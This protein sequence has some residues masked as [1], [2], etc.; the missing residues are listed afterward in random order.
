MSMNLKFYIPLNK[1]LPF[2]SIRLATSTSEEKKVVTSP[3]FGKPVI[4]LFLN[5]NSVNNFQDNLKGVLLG[6]HTHPLMLDLNENY[7]VMAFH[8]KPYALKQLL[9]T[10]AS[11]LT[12]K[13][14]SIKGIKLIESLYELVLKYIEDEKQLIH[15]INDFFE[16]AELHD[17]SH[18]VI[19]FLK[20]LES[21]KPG[22]IS[23]MVKEIGLTERNLERKFKCEVGLSP[24]KY[25]QIR[26]V[27]EVFENLKE[28]ADW[29]QIVFDFQYSDQAHFINEFKKYANIAPGL[30]VRK[31][32]TIAAQ[33]PP[34]SRIEI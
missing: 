17:V 33:L 24:K 18:E 6:Q 20:Y 19:S 9:N 3:P 1:K 32:L 12:N 23:S 4:I 29:Q 5:P 2:D 21:N 28:D 16:S 27:F 7:K 8:L 13:Y 26:R 22:N 15:K 25:L 34:I 14:I 30:Y 31:G 10:D 11:G